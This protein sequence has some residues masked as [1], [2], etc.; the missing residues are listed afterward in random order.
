MDNNLIWQYIWVGAT[1]LLV[2]ILLVVKARRR[3][4]HPDRGSSCCGCSLA[5]RC[6]RTQTKSKALDLSKGRL[7]ERPS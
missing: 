5:E 1:F 7:G 3:R 6:D 4:K 2:A